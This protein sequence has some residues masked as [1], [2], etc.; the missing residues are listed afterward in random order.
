[1]QTE[2]AMQERRRRI[3]ARARE[4]L[5]DGDAD[6]FSVRNLAAGADVSAT[7]IYNLIGDKNTVMLQLCSGMVDDIER[8]LEGI[9]DDLTLEKLEASVALT[10]DLADPVKRDLRRAAHIAFDNLW[11]QGA[12][13]DQIEEMTRDAVARHLR[14][15]RRGQEI[16]TLLGRIPAETLNIQ[17]LSSQMMALLDWTYRRATLAEYR[18]RCFMALY[19]SLAADAAEGTREEIM[20]RIDRLEGR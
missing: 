13:Q 3:L 17:I 11:R 6:S 12:Y 15:I 16:G 9:D 8:A 1:M 20:Q 4:L 10:T 14:V 18:K 19:V 5:A 7:T 2:E